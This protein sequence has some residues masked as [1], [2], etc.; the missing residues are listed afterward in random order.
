MF[1]E[2]FLEQGR[3]LPLVFGDNQSSL[4][5]SR[6]SVVRKRSKHIQ[7][8]FHVVRDFAKYLAYVPTEV[9]RADPL[10]KPLT[11]PKYVGLFHIP[12]L[13]EE[14]ILDD[15]SDVEERAYF[16]YAV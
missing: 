1:L 4:A 6:S 13:G 11:G 14:R 10:T 15:L 3:E 2:W 5:L 7:L 9:N 16:I 12:T 8:R